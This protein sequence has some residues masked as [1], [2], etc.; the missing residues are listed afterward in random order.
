MLYYHLILSE[1]LC[2]FLSVARRVN[3][4][5]S[6]ST[7]TPCRAPRDTCK[8]Y[9]HECAT[10]KRAFVTWSQHEQNLFEICKHIFTLLHEMR[11]RNLKVDVLW[12]YLN[13]FL[14]DDDKLRDLFDR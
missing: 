4:V 11:S 8:Q 5:A 12:K 1:S 14:Q 13:F 10:S 6:R 9:A 3:L 2:R 7:S